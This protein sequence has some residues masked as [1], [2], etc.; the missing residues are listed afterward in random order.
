MNP[1][2]PLTPATIYRAH[3]RYR[4]LTLAAVALAL[5]FV[6][7]L[8]KDV[9]AGSLLFLGV[10]LGLFFRYGRVLGSRV[11]LED[12]RLRLQRPFAP[13]VVVEFRQLAAIHEEGRFGQSLLLHYHPLTAAGL[14]E[15]DE[16]RSLS[17]PALV[18]QSELAEFLDKQVPV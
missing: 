10:A 13:D 16:I 15:L 17:L 11:T 1:T 18:A 14:V 12:R 4:L 3:S 8:S 5:L 9:E 7:D 6:W 2:T